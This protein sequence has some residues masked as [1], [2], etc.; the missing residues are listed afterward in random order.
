MERTEELKAF[1][2]EHHH[3]LLLSWKIRAGISKGVSFDRIK[4]YSDWFFTTYMIPHF[5]KEREVVFPILG[6]KDPLVKKALSNQ[7]RLKKLFLGNKKPPEIALSLG[8]EKLEQ[9]IRFEERQLFK[10]VQEVATSE[11]LEQIEEL[12]K[13]KEFEENKEDEFWED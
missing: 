10:R 4:K 7:R 8:E 13:E 5:K 9:H 1:S 6:K 11:Q 3:G 2:R 12:H